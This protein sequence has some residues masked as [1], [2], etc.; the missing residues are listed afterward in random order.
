MQWPAGRSRRAAG[1]GFPGGVLALRS[2]AISFPAPCI[3]AVQEAAMS[4]LPR[5]ASCQALSCS[6]G[7]PASQPLPGEL[8]AW[9]VPAE[10]RR[11]LRTGGSPNTGVSIVTRRAPL[12]EGALLRA[13]LLPGALLRAPLAQ[14]GRSLADKSGRWQGLERSF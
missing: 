14:R 9:L 10:D 11:T 6:A 2:T 1:R 5:R 8:S 3:P 12:I 4:P 7:L 13:P